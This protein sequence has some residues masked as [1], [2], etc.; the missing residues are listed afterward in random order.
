MSNVQ[1][2]PKEALK[3]PRKGR[4]Q[5]VSK[6]E[7]FRRLAVKRVN[8]AIRYIRIVGNLANRTNYVYDTAQ[9][10]KIVK[11]L[12]AEVKLMRE[13]FFATEADDKSGF[14]L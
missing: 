4:A 6:D 8:N 11:A 1:A 7:A 9:A 10:T 13:R 12:E 2:M 5:A 3:Q 14:Q